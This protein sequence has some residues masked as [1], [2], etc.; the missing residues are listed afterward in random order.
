VEV[1]GSLLE[2]RVRR[3]PDQRHRDLLCLEG[4]FEAV[5]LPGH[6]TARIGVLDLVGTN[7]GVSAHGS[8]RS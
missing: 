4:L 2:V 7:D 1:A 3:D 5:E 8:S 6:V